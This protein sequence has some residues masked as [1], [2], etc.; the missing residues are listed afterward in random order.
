LDVLAAGAPRQ[1]NGSNAVPIAAHMTQILLKLKQSLQNSQKHQT[2]EANKHQREHM[3]QT[4]DKIM[5]S[6]K[7]LLLSYGNMSIHCQGLQYKYV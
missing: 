5:L 6:K 1:I 2:T 3:F 7:H 4:R